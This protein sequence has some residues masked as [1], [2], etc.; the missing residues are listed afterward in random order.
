ML[1]EPT[2]YA[3]LTRPDIAP[4]PTAASHIEQQ[5]AKA[6]MSARRGKAWM[7][8]ESFHKFDLKQPSLMVLRI[9]KT[10]K[11]IQVPAGI[12]PL[13]H[14]LSIVCEAPE[15]LRR[16][17]KALAS[18]LAA[19]SLREHAAPLENGYLAITER[20]KNEPGRLAGRKMRS[21][22]STKRASRL[23]NQSCCLYTRWRR[24][25]RSG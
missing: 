8:R 22:T 12:L 25:V 2:R 1:G 17:E 5:K 19:Q 23:R 14:N 10:P 16:V 4:S 7:S 20:E 13:D 6:G 9:G 18:D 11:G 15:M 3:I 24:P 21:S